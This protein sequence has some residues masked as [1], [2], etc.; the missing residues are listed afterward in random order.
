MTSRPPIAEDSLDQETVLTASA[1]A[2]D[3]VAEDGSIDVL[4]IVAIFTAEWRIGLITAV[5]VFLLGVA[6]VFHLPSQYVA[7]TLLLPKN[8]AIAGN[9]GLSA[10]FSLV[11]P[12]S[13]YITLLTSRGL[14]NDVVRR[15]N[16]TQLFHTQSMETARGAL[17]AMTQIFPGGDGTYTIRVRNESA[18]EA[19]QIANTYVDALRALQ[20][21]MALQAAEVQR[22]FFEAQLQREKDALAAAEQDLE[23]TQ[24]GLGV[25]DVGTQTAIGLSTIASL[26]SQITSLEVH[27]AA[28]LQS[29]TE[30]NPEVQTV[31][32]QI[33][34]LR[35]QERAQESQAGDNSP[36]G[37]AG[38]ASRMPRV[39]LAYARKQRE[40]V[41]H[42]GLV[43][44]LASHFEDLRLG[45]G[46][47]GDNFDVID[48]AVVPETPT[49]PPRRMYLLFAGAL[50]LLLGLFAIAI[51][52]AIR[53][54]VSDAQQRAN[55]RL[56]AASVRS[57]R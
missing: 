36:V 2:R 43:N 38:P 29:E 57:R 31:R 55:L 52:V 5:V 26:R 35:A 21:S 30:Q 11:Q 10:M 34:Q 23:R 42:Q 15:A 44:S 33:A 16:L 53:R 27:L 48:R 28:L 40:V 37:A 1:K 32:S 4:R 49:W 6:Y 46:S 54:L 8:A 22:R 12:A 9:G 13:P 17:S 18:T 50:A 19:A 51:A 56:I 3:A 7:D 39:N 45:M 20:E 47:M 14:E 41:Y 24:E 25:I